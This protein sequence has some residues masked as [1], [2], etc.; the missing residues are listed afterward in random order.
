MLSKHAMSYVSGSNHQHAEKL[1]A[2]TYMPGTG[3]QV[4]CC[5]FQKENQAAECKNQ[6]FGIFW[7]T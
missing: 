1:R 5:I 4:E 6:M 2:L 7:V 3:I